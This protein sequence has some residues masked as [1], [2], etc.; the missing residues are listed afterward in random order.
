MC[1]IYMFVYAKMQ[2][3]YIEVLQFLSLLYIP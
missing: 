1:P 3:V 2:V